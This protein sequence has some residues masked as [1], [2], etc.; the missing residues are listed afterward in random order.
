MERPVMND[1][2][3]PLEDRAVD[4]SLPPLDR[5]RDVAIRFPLL[6]VSDGHGPLVR[7]LAWSW[8]PRADAAL[9]KISQLDVS[10]LPEET[11]AE[12]QRLSEAIGAIVDDLR[13]LA[14]GQ[15]MIGPVA[16]ALDDQAAG[17][18]ADRATWRAAMQA[19]GDAQEGR[20]RDLVQA[21]QQRLREALTQT[22]SDQHDLLAEAR[23]LFEQVF[24]ER[25][26]PVHS[27]IGLVT[28]W[29]RERLG[30]GLAEAEQAY[31]A[32]VLDGLR[33]RDIG[34][35]L[36]VRYLAAVQFRKGNPD[37]AAGT[38]EK[39]LMDCVEAEP[40]ID[41]ARYA[42]AARQAGKARK[43]WRSALEH[44]PLALI[45]LLADGEDV[46]G[47]QIELSLE[48]QRLARER[49]EKWLERW[50]EAARR[51]GEAEK[52]LG[53]SL[54]LS[55][56]LKPETAKAVAQHTDLLTALRLGQAAE[57]GRTRLVATAREAVSAPAKEAAARVAAAR[58]A[59]D[60]LQARRDQAL[61]QLRGVRDQEERVL[62]EQMQQ[63]F[64]DEGLDR[65]CTLSLGVGCGAM[66]LYVI[67]FLVLGAMRIPVGPDTA[68]GKAALILIALPVIGGAVLQVASGIKRAAI[69]NETTRKIADAQ[70]RY[71]ASAHSVAQQFKEQGPK[72]LDALAEAERQAQRSSDALGLLADL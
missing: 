2:L 39:I 44:R 53:R 42:E 5:G 23:T 54:D 69:E 62:R 34:M 33:R 66:I 31:L 19:A 40:W 64:T 52:L 51:I 6:Q 61:E 65:G 37:A 4:P 16:E 47:L 20:G 38:M 18:E 29:L 50:K 63:R 24:G 10:R 14:S 32:G 43:A 3:P 57:E 11:A 13:A 48:A 41:A 8:L 35:T 36:G 25:S 67:A 17:I 28:G 45:E 30:V 71:D 70:Q 60:N 27:A 55:A 58:S 46:S 21:A 59:L 49:A 56:A 68:V 9:G 15:R 12:L 1:A 22:A 26:Q 7:F 72:L